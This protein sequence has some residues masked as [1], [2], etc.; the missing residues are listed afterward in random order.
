MF[1]SI[2][3]FETAAFLI[4]DP[5]FLQVPTYSTLQ[6]LNDGCYEL[7]NKIETRINKIFLIQM[8]MI[9]KKNDKNISSHY[10]K[11]VTLFYLHDLE[12]IQTKSLI[13]TNIFSRKNI[14]FQTYTDI[15][16]CKRWF[17]YFHSKK[18]PK[19]NFSR[20]NICI[21]NIYCYYLFCINAIKI[22]Y[23]NCV[24]NIKLN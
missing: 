23:K 18:R 22:C 9:L 4:F 20:Q 3:T 7:D 13:L 21:D 6:I 16:S 14:M 10:S 11:W 24:N 5:L 17:H 12:K 15:F 19:N 8:S 1:L 2:Q